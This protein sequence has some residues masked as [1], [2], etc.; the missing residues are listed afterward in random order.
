MVTE[1]PGAFRTFARY[2]VDEG[3][4]V[5]HG[6]S[7]HVFQGVELYRGRPVLYDTGDFVDDYAVDQRLRN[8]RSF[9]FEVGVTEEGELTELRLRP[10]EIRDFAVHPA[11]RGATR[12]SRRRMRD[13]SLS[14]DTTFERDG[15]SLVTE[16]GEPGRA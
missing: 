1:P 9:L 12:W 6:H 14:F 7:A 3:V 4:D 5:V 15:E 16:I 2:L 10:T 8:D 11:S 13:L